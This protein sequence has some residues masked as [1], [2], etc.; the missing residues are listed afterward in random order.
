MMLDIR[1]A[2]KYS[3]LELLK[4]FNLTL[5]I[6]LYIGAASDAFS[7]DL[8]VSWTEKTYTHFSNQEPLKDLLTTLAATQKTP[9][10]V[11]EKINTVIS[12]YYKQITPKAIFLEVIKTNGLVWYFDG[13]TLFINREDE[14]QTATVSLN[15]TSASAFTHALERLGVLDHQY[16]WVASDVDQMIY[17]KGPEQFV[18]A[19][20]TMSESLD[21]EQKKVSIYKWVDKNGVTNFSSS[22]PEEGKT[23]VDLK[24]EVHNVLG[25]STKKD[26]IV[27]L[28][29]A[30]YP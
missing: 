11:S 21:K 2:D 29:K 16:H 6:A 18:T 8:P 1:K 27:T 17:F 13:N 9:I 14:M 23:S 5:F 10:V 26:H 24:M 3:R 19:V 4:V 20:L 28:D 15:N 30:K 7:K 22:L 25:K 12:G